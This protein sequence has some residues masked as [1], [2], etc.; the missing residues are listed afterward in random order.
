[1]R[2]NYA[3]KRLKKSVRFY[4]TTTHRPGE[5]QDQDEQINRETAT[6]EISD[7]KVGPIHLPLEAGNGFE[8]DIGLSLEFVFKFAHM[9]FDGI[10]PAGIPQLS[11]P[12]INPCGSVIVLFQKI[13]DDLIVGR[14]NTFLSLTF[15][16]R[17]LP[18]LNVFFNRIAMNARF[19]AMARSE[20]PCR[21]N[22][23]MSIYTSHDIMAMPS[24]KEGLYHDLTFRVVH[25]SFPFLV[26]YCIPV[27]KCL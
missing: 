20:C 25:F 9:E 8:S 26:H 7:L 12:F 15:L 13:V 22:A 23:T 2:K 21:C 27:D 19:L 10:V 18:L 16:L 11:D 17:R 4:L 3:A 5:S 14:Q 1:M 6:T 24:F